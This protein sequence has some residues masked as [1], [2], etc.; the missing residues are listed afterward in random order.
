[1]TIEEIKLIVEECLS[2]LFTKDIPLL[3]HDVSERSIT[4][5][6]AEY[7]QMRFPEFNVDC[8]YNRN[9]VLGPFKAKEI[10]IRREKILK[11]IIQDQD[12]DDL[13]AV[14]TYPDIIVHKRK[15]NEDN[16]LVI[17]VKKQNSKIAK[18]YDYEKLRAFTEI[19]KD[20]QYH[21]DFGVFIMLGTGNERPQKPELTW[22]VEGKSV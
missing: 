11:Q 20:N 5:K 12:E 19:S 2:G 13:L 8:E 16:L 14:S 3:Q 15:T 21:Y 6:L 9:T 1:M 18:D 4:H 10:R 17:E 7:L 22:F